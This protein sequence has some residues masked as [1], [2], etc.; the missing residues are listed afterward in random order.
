MDLRLDGGVVQGQD[1]L[2]E[3]AAVPQAV[4]PLHEFAPFRLRH[5]V[6]NLA[7]LDEV[8][9]VAA[10][11]RA[12]RAGQAAAR[13]VEAAPREGVL[14]A[15]LLVEDLDHVFKLGDGLRDF[16]TALLEPVLADDRAKVSVV[17]AADLAE[18]TECIVLAIVGL[19]RAV[20]GGVG[21]QESVIRGSVFLNVGGQV[22][23]DFVFQILVGVVHPVH[24]HDVRQVA[25][26]GQQGVGVH[27]AV[28]AGGREGPVNVHAEDLGKVRME[29]RLAGVRELLVRR[30]VILSIPGDGL[31]RAERISVAGGEE[32]QRER[33]RSRQNQAERE[34]ESQYFLHWVTSLKYCARY[35]LRRFQAR[36]ARCEPYRKRV[37]MNFNKQNPRI[38]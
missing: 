24:A 32:L 17:P 2:I 37:C 14:R 38:P 10:G 20:I 12:E 22:P 16:Q 8:G 1:V 15:V 11:V 27:F 7:V 5:R 6:A 13:A 31:I 30:K 36:P 34:D 19:H 29:R 3:E 25:R 23:D 33:R 18:E 26:I 21:L 9:V 4:H 35:C 28:G